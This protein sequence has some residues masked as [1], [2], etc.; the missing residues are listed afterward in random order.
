MSADYREAGM[1]NTIF[2]AE[3]N[4][5]NEGR[6]NDF[7]AE[8][9]NYSEDYWKLIEK[10]VNGKRVFY[11]QDDGDK[12][13][14]DSNNKLIKEYNK[15]FDV[16]KDLYGLTD[17]EIAELKSNYQKNM[18]Y[19]HSAGNF[20]YDRPIMNMNALQMIEQLRNSGNS[21]AISNRAL[22]D[23]KYEYE[24][25]SET[26][27]ETKAFYNAYAADLIRS[28]TDIASV[29]LGLPYV[30]YKGFQM[31]YGLANVGIDLYE[32]SSTFGFGNYLNS[33][34]LSY[35]DYYANNQAQARG[36]IASMVT[37]TAA[38][39]IVASVVAEIQLMKA[40]Q[41]SQMTI[42]KVDDLYPAWNDNVIR[43]QLGWTDSFDSTIS[44]NSWNEFQKATKGIF[45]NRADAANFYQQLKDSNFNIYSYTDDVTAELIQKS[46]LGIKDPNFVL[47]LTPN[48][49]MTPIQAGI[50][51]ALPRYNTA[52]S[53]FETSFSN[54]DYSKILLMRRVTGNVYMQGG[55]GYEI[56]Y[57]GW[58]PLDKILRLR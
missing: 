12:N 11:L 20:I 9:Y 58:I 55:G 3:R 1:L 38:T 14:K 7:V 47:Y 43:S 36:Q 16:F 25:L 4:A 54:L 46:Q 19:Y 6:L 45:H 34:V 5:L 10:E 31:S 23:S 21:Y 26:P 18:E 32:G 44:L 13:L 27:E 24:L 52:T 15:Y 37:M 30:A 41:L 39:S 42:S 49:N 50:E 35:E 2:A 48:G 56:L 40:S 51:L 22:Q 33:K 17:N 53:L 8:N 28:I 29:G 57:N